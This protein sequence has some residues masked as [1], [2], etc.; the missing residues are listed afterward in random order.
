[1][2]TAH[3]EDDLKL[4]NLTDGVSELTSA[5]LEVF[6]KKEPDYHSI[7]LALT[8]L[9]LTHMVR[10]S[11]DEDVLVASVDF[12]SEQLNNIMLTLIEKDGAT[13]Q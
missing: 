10:H 7:F 2:M 1:M 11:E 4:L 5:I 9:L 12:V 8:V 13:L 3:D 6:E